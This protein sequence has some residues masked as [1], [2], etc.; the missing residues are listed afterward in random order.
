MMIRQDAEMEAYKQYD[1]GKNDPELLSDEDKT[2]RQFTYIERMK[3]KL[4]IMKFMTQ[5][6]EQVRVLRPQLDAL[7]AASKSVRTS[8]KLKRILEIILALGRLHS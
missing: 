3:V 7:T 5:F 1:L 2:M 6:D 4:D 8:Q